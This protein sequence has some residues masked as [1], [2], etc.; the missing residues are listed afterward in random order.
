VLLQIPLTSV[1]KRRR[2]GLV[3]LLS[4]L[5]TGVGFGTVGFAGTSTIL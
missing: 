2:R 5:V 4:A 1:L 3:L